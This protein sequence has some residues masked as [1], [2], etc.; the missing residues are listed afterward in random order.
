MN[1]YFCSLSSHRGDE[2]P[3]VLHH[4]LGQRQRRS[5]DPQ[6]GLPDLLLHQGQAVVQ[7]PAGQQHQRCGRHRLSW[8]ETLVT[9]FTSLFG[10]G[11][12]KRVSFRPLL[13]PGQNSWWLIKFNKAEK[14]QAESDFK[15]SGRSALTDRWQETQVV[16]SV[17]YQQVHYLILF[18]FS[19]FWH[20]HLANYC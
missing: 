4:I 10:D 20:L 7:T 17:L 19:T 18:A 11:N 2:A 14:K 15:Q 13:P 1:Y 5:G 6:P 16:Y 3:A 12:K 9:R 8:A